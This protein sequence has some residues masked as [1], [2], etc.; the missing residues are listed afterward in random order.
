MRID[1]DFNFH[2]DDDLNMGD[3]T[4]KFPASLETESGNSYI[5]VMVS[6][7]TNYIHIEPLRDRHGQT[8]ASAYERGINFYERR[9]IKTTYERLDNETS[10]AFQRMCARRGI[11]IQYVPEGQHRANISERAIRTVKNLIISAPQAQPF[12][13][14]SGTD[15]SHT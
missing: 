3:L 2:V 9:G 1:K 11:T 8:I 14:Q 12:P 7:K 4:G 15:S 10:V 5:L 6:T 13:W